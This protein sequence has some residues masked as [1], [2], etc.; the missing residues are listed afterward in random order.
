VGRLLAGLAALACGYRFSAGGA[1]L[2]EGIRTVCAPVLSNGTAEPGLE[3]AFTESVRA[4]LIRAGVH[5]TGAAD[6][7]ARLLGEIRG[8]SAAPTLLTRGGQLA[9]YRLLAVVHFRLMKGDRVVSEAEV[10]STEDY[11]PAP[12]GDVLPS[13]AN[14]QAALRRLGETVARDAYERLASGW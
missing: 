9:S 7:E 8:V 12:M 5:R 14:R 11:L 13:E 1:P 6:C 2:P 4:R 10:T 3:V